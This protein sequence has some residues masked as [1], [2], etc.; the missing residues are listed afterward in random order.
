MIE[1]LLVFTL[2]VAVGFV[3][4][5]YWFRE[6]IGEMRSMEEFVDAHCLPINVKEDEE[7]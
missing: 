1:L 6:E 7:D 4:A 3:A 5:L 2:G